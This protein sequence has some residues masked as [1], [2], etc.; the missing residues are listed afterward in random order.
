MPVLVIAA[1]VIPE[2]SERSL[3]EECSLVFSQVEMKDCLVK[4]VDESQRLL[5]QAEKEV[6]NALSQWDEDK[7]Y[8]DQAKRKFHISNEKFLTYRKTYCDFSSSLSGGSAGNTQKIMWLA[9][10]AEI[11]NHQVKQLQDVVNNIVQK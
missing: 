8:A 7:K 5:R 1:S 2:A 4:K 6:D 3:R 10:V 9:C 11:N